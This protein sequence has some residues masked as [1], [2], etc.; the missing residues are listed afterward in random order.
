MKLFAV[1]LACAAAGCASAPIVSPAPTSSF[2]PLPLAEFPGATAISTGFDERTADADWRTHDQALFAL[3][4][5]KDGDV[6]RWLLHIDVSTPRSITLV[7]PPATSTGQGM[8]GS[9]LAQPVVVATRVFDAAGKLLTATDVALPA[10]FL[11]HGLLPKIDRDTSPRG[12]DDASKEEVFESIAQILR[13]HYAI[14]ALLDVVRKNE[15][16]DDYFWRVVDAPGLF[17]VVAHMGVSI[18]VDMAFERSV[19]ATVPPPLPAVERAYAVPLRIDVNGST[20]LFVDLLAT[21][22]SRPYAICGGIVAAVARHPTQPDTSL[23]LQLIAAHC[24]T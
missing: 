6:V 14:S 9:I 2:A 21:D 22:A 18:N 13:A 16:L 20:A 4:L 19:A 12:Q 1:V 3:Q 15:E 7:D 5:E 24:G 11:A 23:R 8:S 17:S 10:G